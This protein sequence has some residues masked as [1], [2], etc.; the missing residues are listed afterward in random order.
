MTASGVAVIESRASDPPMW[1]GDLPWAIPV[2]ALVGEK[3]KASDPARVRAERVE[4]IAQEIARIT[5]KVDLAVIENGSF[6]SQR[7]ARNLADERTALRVRVIGLLDC[8]IAL[9]APTTLKLYATGDG[10]AEKRSV[11]DSTLALYELPSRDDNLI[12]AFV[13]ARMG[14]RRLGQPIEPEAEEHHLRAMRT[15]KWEA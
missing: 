1:A 12:D 2:F 5:G 9:V 8:P 3:G 7:A 14:V 13:L 15:P 10:K 11:V 4:A 6:G